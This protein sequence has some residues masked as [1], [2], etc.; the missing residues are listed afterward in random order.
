MSWRDDWP[1]IGED[2]DGDGKGEPVLRWPKPRVAASPA[3]L[4]PST[5][6]EFEN[7]R[8]GL[9]W[10]WPAN[11]APEWWSLTARRGVLRLS[12][13]PLPGS[14]VNLW[15][16]PNLLLQKLPAPAFTATTRLE[17]AGLR[18]GE[19]AGLLVMGLD[20]A[21]LAL[22][23]TDRGLS[24]RR[25]TAKDADCGSPEA[26]EAAVPLAEGPVHLRVSVEPEAVYRFSFSRD[27][28]SFEGVGEAFAARPG[29]WIG[30]K[31]GLFALAPA[32]N[33]KAGH[34]DFEW[35]RIEGGR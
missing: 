20:Y 11:P 24:L 10:Q 19:K 30:A 29:L 22:E 31:V 17:A 26:E 25:V 9:A 28:R 34:A 35:F 18:V 21:Y 3:P 33:R 15:T 23:R 6:D 27:G 2:R 8:L 1:V 32:G 4:V 16:V 12:A 14:G 7:A 13:V 5:A